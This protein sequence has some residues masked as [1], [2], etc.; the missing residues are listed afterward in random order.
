MKISWQDV[1]DIQIEISESK[2][3]NFDYILYGVKSLRLGGLQI[4][5]GVIICIAEM[6]CYAGMHYI[7]SLKA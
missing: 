6:L 3:V 1:Q 4:S 5:Y 2:W 7:L